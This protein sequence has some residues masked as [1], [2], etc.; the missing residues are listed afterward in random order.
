[1]KTS[2]P[3]TL[4]IDKDLKQRAKEY[5]EA[6]TPRESLSRVIQRALYNLLKNK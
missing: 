3:F 1:M 6:Q 4:R 2:E 5:G